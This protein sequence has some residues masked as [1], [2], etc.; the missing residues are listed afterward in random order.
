M[1]LFS[2][3][4][5]PPIFGNSRQYKPFLRTDFRARC[6]YCERPEEYMGG[7]EAFEVEHFKPKSKF[8]ELDCVY[9]NLY[10]ACRGCNAHKSETWPS[11]EQFARGMRFADPCEEDPYIHHLAENADGSV[12]GTT[13]CGTYTNLHIRL[14]RDDIRR[15]RRLRAQG[16]TDLPILTTLVAALEQLRSVTRDSEND[17]VAER[18]NA[19]R[20]L[21]EESRRRFR[22]G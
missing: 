12:K 20:R 17:E 11:D 2:R 22:I 8:A 15:W 21:I 4:S 6:A 16:I 13:R 14:H 3:E 1:A 18:I 19:L 7:E 9:A 5:Q 10:Y